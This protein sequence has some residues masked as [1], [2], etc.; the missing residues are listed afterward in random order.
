MRRIIFLLL[1]FSFLFGFSSRISPQ[2]TTRFMVVGD[3]HH[4][5]PVTAFNQT[6]LFELVLAAIAEKVKFIFFTGDLV[7]QGFSSETDKDS[8]L[9][10]WRFVLDTLYTHNIRVYAC[11]GNN[12]YSKDAWD[13]LFAGKYAFPQNGPAG[14]KNLTYAL[15]ISNILFVTLD[16]YTD[17]HKINQDWLDEQLAKN[18]RPHVFIAGHE[19]AFKL[20]HSNCMGAYPDER[21]IFW[22]SLIK[23]GVK[24]F[25]C[26][27]DHFYDHAV[28]DDGDGNPDNDVH[29]LIVGTGGFAHSDAS[30]DGDN[31][32]WTPVRMFHE[33]QNGFVLV[34]VNESVEKM[35]WKHR[36]DS[37]IFE[38][39]GD[40][41][42]FIASSVQEGRV[43]KGYFVA[44]NYPN[45]F[46]SSTIISYAVAYPSR[47]SI[48]IFDLFGNEIKTLVDKEQF[49]G[50]Y[51][52][53]FTATDL[54]SGLYLCRF[55]ANQFIQI[56]KM[57]LIR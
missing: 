44:Q 53:E 45:P 7:I 49:P 50:N 22:E 51:K 34:E 6:M 23:A 30:Y 42:E 46:N 32:R 24:I 37:N 35:T 20:L 40:S 56:K 48:K 54:P 2:E 36:V 19:P 31:G 21:N 9:K 43:P 33:E 5:S 8:V 16:L 14:E 17:Y 47:I 29:Q 41:Y 25:F 13:S 4:Y 12:D 10:D 18:T 28:I 26:G 57:I 11:R 39:G 38:D 55:R 52:M 27:H 15:Q 1:I 3:T